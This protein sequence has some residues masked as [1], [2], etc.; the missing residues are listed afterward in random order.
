MLDKTNA[1]IN[2]YQTTI[3]TAITHPHPAQILRISS[4][5]LHS[6]LVPLTAGY[7]VNVTLIGVISA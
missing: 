2:P 3:N 7:V 5:I 6:R 4:A 1:N